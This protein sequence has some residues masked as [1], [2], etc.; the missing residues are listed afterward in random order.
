MKKIDHILLASS[1]IIYLFCYLNMCQKYSNL[2]NNLE[3]NNFHYYNWSTFVLVMGIL[4]PI[5]IIWEAV[6]M[7]REKQRMIKFNR[8]HYLLAYFDGTLINLPL[9]LFIILYFME[10]QPLESTKNNMVDHFS[11]IF[12]LISMV[13]NNLF[14]PMALLD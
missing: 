13:I 1:L 9:Y 11:T 3:S 7:S 10:K 2:Y 5:F 4:S 8:W 12:V 6:I 14:Y